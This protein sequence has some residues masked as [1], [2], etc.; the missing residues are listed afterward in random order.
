MVGKSLVIST[1]VS[2]IDSGFSHILVDR[3]VSV[4]D[5]LKKINFDSLFN[6]PY[7]KKVL[8]TEV[9]ETI[10]RFINGF[11]NGQRV[12]S[13]TL[14]ICGIREGG[15]RGRTKIEHVIMPIATALRFKSG[16]LSGGPAEIFTAISSGNLFTEATDLKGSTFS[17]AT[18]DFNPHV[19]YK[20]V[21]DS[22]EAMGFKTFSFAAEFEQIQQVFL[23]FDLALG[24]VGLIALLT[25]SLGIVNTM[26]MSI[27]ERR[28]E[29]GILKSLGADERD[30]RLL[31]LVESAVIGFLGAAGG[32][33]SGWIIT[34]IAAAVAKAFMEN[35][36]IPPIDPFS[37]PLWLIGISMAIGIVV[38]IVA[39][40]YPAAR[41]ARVDPV[42]ALRND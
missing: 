16:G 19:P 32:I 29:I 20:S 28:R 31:F 36:G 35:E 14:T 11:L 2:V 12:I 38:S 6:G 33:L 3:G 8:R 5:R 42:E 30:I 25:A 37:L 39:G 9:N 40:F 22:I 41:A 4:L 10:R 26:V 18:V 17:Q 23:Y 1:R 15:G 27:T 13:D 7:M 21:K 34:R 24:L